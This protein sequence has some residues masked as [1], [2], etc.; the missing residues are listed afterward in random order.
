MDTKNRCIPLIDELMWRV[1][2]S[3]LCCRILLIP[4]SAAHIP[5]GKPHFFCFQILHFHVED[6]VVCNE[7]FEALIMMTC[8]PINR[9]STKAGSNATQTIFVHKRFF[10]EF[11]DS[12]EII[13]HTLSTVITT[14]FFVPFLTEARQTAAV[15]SDNDIIVGSHDLEVPTI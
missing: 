2:K 5:V 14:D 1:G 11:V 8:Q 10:R 13:L 3:A 9:E 15:R 7:G 4:V 6:T 12:R